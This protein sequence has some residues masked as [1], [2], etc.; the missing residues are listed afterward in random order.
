VSR[1][2]IGLSGRLNYRHRNLFQGAELFST[3]VESGVEVN[4]GRTVS[5]RVNSANF[6]V[7]N[8]LLIPR[9]ID[10][11]RFYRFINEIWPGRNGF[12]GDRT[13]R[14]L[15][16]GN[17]N[18]GLGYQYLSLFELY[19]YHSFTASMGYD[20]QPD[21]QRRLQLNHI[22][23]DVFL[24]ETKS[25]FDAILEN[26]R[27]LRESF[28]KQL[29]TGFLFR[30]YRFTQ[31][32]RNRPRGINVSLTHSAEVSGL[33]IFGINTLY[34]SLADQRGGFEIGNGDKA[35]SFSQFAKL[36]VDTRVRHVIS[37]SQELAFR[38]STGLAFPYGPFTQQVP[39]IKQFYV[40]GPSSIRAWQIR[41]LGP[42]GFQDPFNNPDGDLP[43]Y[44]T[45]DIKIEGAA[46][47]RFD[48]AWIFEGALFVDA[49]NVWTVQDDPTRPDAVFS[50]NFLKQIAVGTGI[51]LRMDFTYFRIRLDFGYKLRNPYPIEGKYWLFDNFKDFSFR[52]FTTNFAIGYPF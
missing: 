10:P 29:F 21:L 19:D 39:Y 1:T 38:F 16:E 48:I 37:P 34:N 8:D 52:Q 13:Y 25:N 6:N 20:A 15:A 22:G 44:Q 35:L 31:T 30:D 11:I 17:T 3:N 7:Q 43:F 24:P 27:F 32:G 45:G 28:R 9:F 41:E 50:N 49:G 26:N 18:I 42:G 4:L 46:E 23:I 51:G 36:E 40:G 14:W 12:L 33:E 5:S 47:Y 2:L